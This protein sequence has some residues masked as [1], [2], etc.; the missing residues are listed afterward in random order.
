MVGS[1][2][3]GY[4]PLFEPQTRFVLIDG[5]EVSPETMLWWLFAHAVILAP[6][7]VVLLGLAWRRRLSRR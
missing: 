5:I 6:L 1:D 2:L 4:T 7:L 3:T